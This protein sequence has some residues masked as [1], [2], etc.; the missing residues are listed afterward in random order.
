MRFNISLR[1]GG[2]SNPKDGAPGIVRLVSGQDDIA[3]L[4]REARWRPSA[5]APL[6]CVRFATW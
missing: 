4:P 5:P 3:P 1:R 6:R 2:Y